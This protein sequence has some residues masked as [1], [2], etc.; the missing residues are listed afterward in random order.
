M[1]SGSSP[2]WSVWYPDLEGRILSGSV[3]LHL[4][5]C[6]STPVPR[7]RLGECPSPLVPLL[8][9]REC[10]STLVPR[11]CLGECLSPLVPLLR[12]RR[13]ILLPV[14]LLHLRE[15]PAPVPLTSTPPVQPQ[16][17]C[18]AS[19]P[20][21]WYLLT[22]EPNPNHTSCSHSLHQLHH[23]VYKGLLQSPAHPWVI[24]SYQCGN[25][26]LRCSACVAYLAFVVYQLYLHVFLQVVIC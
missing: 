15:C 3:L 25:Y 17:P 9:L 13:S 6:P 5:E 7:L 20:P 2:G 12:L 26:S 11:L 1:S 23:A 10:P 19:T 22:A 24:N 16:F 8:H 21:L 14:P 18:S 4:R